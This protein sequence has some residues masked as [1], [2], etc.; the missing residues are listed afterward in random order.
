MCLV[1]VFAMGLTYLSSDYMVLIIKL[2]PLGMSSLTLSIAITLACDHVN[3]SYICRYY[4]RRYCQHWFAIGLR[5]G[6]LWRASI[7]AL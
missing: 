7:T 4:T 6:R 5:G 1:G 3:A 2:A